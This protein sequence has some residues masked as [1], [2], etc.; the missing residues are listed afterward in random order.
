LRD[1]HRWCAL[2]VLA[3]CWAMTVPAQQKEG[4]KKEEKKEAP[5]VRPPVSFSKDVV[6]VISKNCMPCHA[7]DQFNPSEL[8]LDSYE[9]LMKGGKHGDAIQPGKAS[10]SI[11]V[12]KL[13]EPP[14]F[15]DRMPFDPRKKRKKEPMK[16][17]TD[18]EISIITEWVNQGAKNN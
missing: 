5:R 2:V 17:L 10:E 14:P 18:E 4:E 15:G 1:C 12:Q 11:F 3:T 13:L 7:E 16:P 8:S 6:P 9:L